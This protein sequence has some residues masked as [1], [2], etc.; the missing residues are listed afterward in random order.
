MTIDFLIS[1]YNFDEL[2]II[3]IKLNNNELVVDFKINAHLE[4]IANGYRPELDLD[5]LE[6]FIFEIENNNYKINKPYD[7]KIIKDNQYYILLNNNK[8]K[9]LSNEVKVEKNL[10]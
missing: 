9:L 6:R 10:E 1:V 5:V 7:F 3:N 8:I 2:E 4:L